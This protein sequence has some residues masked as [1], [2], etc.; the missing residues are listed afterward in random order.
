MRRTLIIMAALYTLASAIALAQEKASTFIPAASESAINCSGLIAAAPLT[1]D[2]R[3]FGE[4]DNELFG[5]SRI[6]TK[7]E[8]IYL[9]GNLRGVEA[10]SEWRLVRPD[11]K[12]APAPDLNS[13][14]FGQQLRPP[15]PWFPGQL[16]ALRAAGTPYTDVGKVKVIRVTAK[17][18]VAQVVFTCDGATEGDLAIPFKP[19]EIPSYDPAL[20]FDRFA[21]TSATLK[22]SIVA[23]KLAGVWIEDGGIAFVNLGSSAGIRPGQRLRVFH[24]RRERP[25]MGPVPAAE[26]RENIGELVV[27]SVEGKSAAAQV[28]SSLRQIVVGDGVELE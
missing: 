19:R 17:G 23:S 12:M 28:V 8:F 14:A 11:A 21:P 24:V 16:A 15:L 20:K 26:P 7:G 18:A 22:G 9:N 13:S 3:V 4:A 5:T 25:L 10:G 6:S 2:L 27:L 1:A